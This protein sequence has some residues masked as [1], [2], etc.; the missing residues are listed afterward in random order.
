PIKDMSDTFSLVK[1]SHQFSVGLNYN[2][3]STFQQIQ[4]SAMF[5]GVTF[6]IA[7]NDPIA[8]GNTSLFTTTNFPGATQSQLNSASG[9]YATLTGR[10]SSFTRSV[11]LDE[12]TKKYGATAPVDRDHIREIGLFI[13]DTWRVHPNLTATI[14]LRY[15]K[16]FAFVNENGLYSQVGLAGIWGL[17]GI[18][19]LFKPGTL[20]GTAPTYNKLDPNNTYKIPKIWAPSVGLAWQ[21]P[22]MGGFLGKVFGERAGASVLRAGYAIASVREGM[23]VLTST[24]GGNQGLT[25]STSID[26]STFPADFGAPGSVL[27]RDATLPVRSGVPSTPQYPIVPTFTNSLNDFDPNLKLGYVQSWNIGLQRELGRNSV[28]EVRFT[29]NH[30]V[31]LWQRYSLQETNIFENGF[32]DEFKVAANNLAI[33]RQTNPSSNNFGNQGLP[34]QKAIPIL[35]IGLGTTCCND[36]ATANNLILGQAGTLAGGTSGIAGNAT[37]MQAL[38]NAGYPS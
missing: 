32:L 4:G 20:T 2:Q 12:A 17:S 18:G 13:Q 19:N 9:L 15:E 36:S 23:N 1:G 38:I 25:V 5:P 16:E 29:G 34:G 28:V 11:A 35:Q 30:G 7:T 31:H 8:N 37:R 24:Y 21:L 26:P 22:K 33:A 3:V 27:F 10:V 6:G 14:G